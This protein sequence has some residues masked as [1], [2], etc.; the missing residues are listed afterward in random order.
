MEKS[1]KIILIIVGVLVGI[2]LL[3]TLQARIFKHSPI[4]S[5]KEELEDNDSWVDKGIIID[6]Y[7]CTKEQ[8]ILTVSWHFKTSK[9]TCPKYKED[10]LLNQL[11]GQWIADGTQIKS[12]IDM[13]DGEHIYADDYDLPYYL[14]INKDGT[15]LLNLNNKTNYTE[16]GKYSITDNKINFNPETDDGFIWS[17]KLPNDNELHCE[18][19]ATIFLSVNN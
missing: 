19:Y 14:N 9:F 8:D 7:Y 18:N 4:I 2:V 1:V 16:K 3:D 10:K 15:Y 6:T 12:I 11:E 5:W 17:C 13:V